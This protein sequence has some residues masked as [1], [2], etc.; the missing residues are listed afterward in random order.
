MQSCIACALTHTLTVPRPVTNVLFRSSMRFRVLRVFLKT[1]QQFWKRRTF[2]AENVFWNWTRT[3]LTRDGEDCRSEY[4]P[5]SPIISARSRSLKESPNP[6]S[7]PQYI[8]NSLCDLQFLADINGKQMW[9]VIYLSYR[10]MSIRIYCVT[11]HYGHTL[12]VNI[13]LVR[14]NCAAEDFWN[15]QQSC[16]SPTNYIRSV[17]LATVNTKIMGPLGHG[18]TFQKTKYTE[19]KER[20]PV[21]CGNVGAGG[22]SL[23]DNCCISLEPTLT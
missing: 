18:L 19:N 2:F 9:R 6:K 10:H 15:S 16:S 11:A 13:I 14:N 23:S 4:K 12:R 3:K 21:D 1:V 22:F 5:V 8:S 17:V 7:R 20:G